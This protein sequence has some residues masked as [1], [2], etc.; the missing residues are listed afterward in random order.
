MPRQRQRPR[1]RR[2]IRLRRKGRR[3]T[4]ETKAQDEASNPAPEKGEAENG[5]EA[6]AAD[7]EKLKLTLCIGRKNDLSFQLSAY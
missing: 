3:K 6:A 2:Q 4:A 5:G 7:G 1:M